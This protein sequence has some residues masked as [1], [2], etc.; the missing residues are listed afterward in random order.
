MT[1]S[2]R[3][4][5]QTSLELQRPLASDSEIIWEEVTCWEVQGVLAGAQGERR[6]L[7]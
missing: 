3:L 1:V 5:I 6:K 4:P 7:H 2:S